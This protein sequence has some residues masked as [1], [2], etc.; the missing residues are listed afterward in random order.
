MTLCHVTLIS[1]RLVTR[2]LRSSNLTNLF[3][4]KTHLTPTQKH[5]TTIRTVP[6]VTGEPTLTFL[7]YLGAIRSLQMSGLTGR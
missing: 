2:P 4:P 3:R 6:R 5:I 7:M 1:Q